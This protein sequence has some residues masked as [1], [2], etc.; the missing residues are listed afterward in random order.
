[1]SLITFNGQLLA[2]AGGLATGRK[3][4]CYSRT[5]YCVVQT[6][7][8]RVV[9]RYIIDLADQQYVPPPVGPLFWWPEGKPCDPFCGVDQGTYLDNNG[10]LVCTC[11][12]TPPGSGWN[13]SSIDAAIYNYNDPVALARRCPP[14]NPPPAGPGTELKKLLSWVGIRSTDSCQCDDRA[15]LMDIMGADECEER[16]DEIV[17]WL[18]EEAEERGLLFSRTVAALA[19]MQAIRNSRRREPEPGADES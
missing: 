11:G 10:V 3:C 2:K 15:L 12:G 8:Y 17:D 7:L 14:V 4:C 18:E 19:V 16:L 5:K 9:A 13:V 1:M 6:V